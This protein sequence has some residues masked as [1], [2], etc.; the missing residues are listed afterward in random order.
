MGG[1]R[2]RSWGNKQTWGG[3]QGG[4][5]TWGS[6]NGGSWGGSS[7]GSAAATD[8]TA[9]T[10]QGKNWKCD[11]C[12]LTTNCPWWWKCGRESCQAPWKAKDNTGTEAVTPAA[13]STQELTVAREKLAMLA[14]ILDPD[15]AALVTWATKVHSLEQAQKTSVSTAERLRRLLHAQKQ[16]ESKQ[17]AALTAMDKAKAELAKATALLKSRMEE[18]DSAVAE[19]AANSLE[20]AEVTRSAS[21]QVTPVVNSDGTQLTMVQNL[22][23]QIDVLTPDDLAEAGLDLAGMGGFLGIF[24]KI[25]A[26][27][28]RANERSESVTIPPAAAAGAAQSSQIP[29]GQPEPVAQPRPADDDDEDDLDD[30]VSSKGAAA[31]ELVKAEKLLEDTRAMDEVGSSG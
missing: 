21:P 15:D 10:S 24:S 25:Q 12:G 9:A 7:A 3:G 17:T 2:N 19:I 28:D 27:L 14:S 5:G 29:I 1:N 30:D 26:L 20:I 11:A 13:A 18:C 6:S 8:D 16:L 4:Y 31:R 22:R 23:A